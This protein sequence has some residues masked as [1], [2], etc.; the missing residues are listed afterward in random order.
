MLMQ[1]PS[2]LDNAIQRIITLFIAAVLKNCPLL[3]NGVLIQC[4]IIVPS[5]NHSHTTQQYIKL[6][7]FIIIQKLFS[8]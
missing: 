8:Y 6:K 4:Y 7:L 2:E 5:S 1:L 3:A